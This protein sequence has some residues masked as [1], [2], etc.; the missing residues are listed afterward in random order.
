ML[1][2]EV[3]FQHVFFSPWEVLKHPFQFPHKYTYL[4]FLGKLPSF[5]FGG[6]F[7]LQR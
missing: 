5:L 4:L 3:K 2:E 6:L 7:C 1:E